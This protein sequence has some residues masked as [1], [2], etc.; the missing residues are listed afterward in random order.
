MQ[1]ENHPLL[2]NQNIA[3][4]P[5]FKGDNNQSMTLFVPG[6]VLQN[7]IRYIAEGRSTASSLRTVFIAYKDDTLFPSNETALNVS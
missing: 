6:T 5:E 7:A 3:F 1:I 2:A 4:T